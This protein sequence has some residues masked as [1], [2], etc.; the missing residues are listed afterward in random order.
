M[1]IITNDL[2]TGDKNSRQTVYQK[3]FPWHI[4]H[5][6]PRLSSLGGVGVGN[7]GDVAE[8]RL[9]PKKMGFKMT[10][11][12]HYCRLLLGSQLSYTVNVS[13]VAAP[14]RCLLTATMFWLLFLMEGTLPTT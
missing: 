7:K 4:Y 12:Q 3:R 11:C 14:Q 6:N 5:H 1:F 2:T 8:M 10:M 9:V 13:P